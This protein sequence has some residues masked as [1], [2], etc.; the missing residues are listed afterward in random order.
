MLAK[1]SNV[2][3]V[4]IGMRVGKDRLYQYIHNLGFGRKTGLPLPAESGGMLRRPE[5]WLKDSIGSVP[6]GHEI[7]T[8]T[9]QLAQ[10]CSV[11]ANGG[12]LVRPKIILKR[13]FPDGKVGNEPS[14]A[15]VRVLKPET[16]ITMRQLMERVMFPGGTGTAARVGGGYSS[17]GKTGS[18]QIY[19]FEKKRY[20]SFYNASF[21]GFAPVTNPSVVVVVTLN[22]SRVFGGVVAAPVFKKVT[23]EVLRVMEVP[24]DVPQPDA[25]LIADA[26]PPAQVM[27]GPEPPPPGEIEPETAPGDVYGPRVPD[28]HGM[29]AREVVKTALSKG[30]PITLNGTGVA[31][32]QRPRAGTIL[33]RGEKVRVE[34]AR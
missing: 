5:R 24:K 16:A 10:A 15:P 8:T 20:T 34:L 18:A 2:G 33:P 21:M 17:A 1:S 26:A 19:D 32:M 3:A 9:V 23:Q 7:S 22:H 13:Q 28:F 31:K 12:L 11:I 4:Q 6:M 29:T 30:L 25:P 27:F 14:E